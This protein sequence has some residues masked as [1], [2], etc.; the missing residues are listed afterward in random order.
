[1]GRRGAEERCLGVGRVLARRRR[2]GEGL[3]LRWVKG[4]VE[5]RQELQE[6]Q[7]RGG[8]WLKTG[9]EWARSRSQSAGIVTTEHIGTV[10]QPEQLIRHNDLPTSEGSKST[11]QRSW[12]LDVFILTEYSWN[13]TLF[14]KKLTVELRKSLSI[15]ILDS[16]S[17]EWTDIFKS[18]S[19]CAQGFRF[20]YFRQPIK[21]NT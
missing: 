10:L 5:S 1:M 11:G 18:I 9:G 13:N 19:Y 2:V 7:K 3:G 12:V 20:S 17:Y 8:L 16:Y 14:K 15:H 21:V 4:G 6:E